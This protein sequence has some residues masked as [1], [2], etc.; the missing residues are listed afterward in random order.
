MAHPGGV[1][2]S[3]PF[4][5]LLK[6]NPCF[7]SEVSKLCKCSTCCYFKTAVTKFAS[8]IE[9]KPDGW[10]SGKR[11]CYQ[12]RQGRIQERMHSPPAILKHVFDRYDLSIISNVFSNSMPHAQSIE[13]VRTKCIIFG[14][15]LSFRGKNLNKI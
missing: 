8:Y 11:H 6:P 12:C 5:P 14:K 4:P 2:G 13:N 1:R 7:Y 10:S 3:N 15:T 9:A